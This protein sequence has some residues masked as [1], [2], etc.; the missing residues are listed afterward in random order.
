MKK[1]VLVLML[2]VSSAFAENEVWDETCVTATL[3]HSTGMEKNGY[4]TMTLCV[5]VADVGGTTTTKYERKNLIFEALRI[6]KFDMIIGTP[7]LS[8]IEASLKGAFGKT[9]FKITSLFEK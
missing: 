9:G 6:R 5:A 8:K 3:G 2:M 4:K 7:G 1:F